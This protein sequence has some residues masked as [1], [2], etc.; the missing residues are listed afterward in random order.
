MRRFMTIAIDP[1]ATV[2]ARVVVVSAEA[3]LVDRSAAELRKVDAT[4]LPLSALASVSASPE[5]CDVVVLF[6]DDFEEE[7]LASQLHELQRGATAPML[8]V[9]TSHPQRWMSSVERGSSVVVHDTSW[10]WKLLDAMLS[11]TRV[12]DSGSRPELPFTD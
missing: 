4:F 10:T 1:G 2:R 3:A 6:A 7:S 11:A 12:D 9:V 8:V 5:Q